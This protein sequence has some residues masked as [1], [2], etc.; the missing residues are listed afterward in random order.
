MSY[1]NII[2]T[3]GTGLVFLCILLSSPVASGMTALGDG[4][5]AA[6]R[7]GSGVSIGISGTALI[8]VGSY[9][10]Q[11]TDTKNRIEFNNIVWSNGSG[12]G[13]SF[14]TPVG[15]PVTHDIGTDISGRT[16]VYIHDSTQ[17]SPRTF[18][19]SLHFLEYSAG[20]SGP[21]NIDLGYYNPG[22]G[23]L[24]YITD[25]IVHDLG[26]IE[27][28]DITVTDNNLM[29]GAHGGLDFYQEAKTDI[30]SYSALSGTGTGFHYNYNTTTALEF[31]GIH[32]FGTPTVAMVPEDTSTWTSYPG[33]FKI[34]SIADG[35]AQVDIGTD[36]SGVTNMQLKLPMEG[37]IRVENV[38]FGGSDFGQLALDSINVHRLA[39]QINPN[40]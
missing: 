11:D 4:D 10:Y 40:P 13:F 7:G 38:K 30:G 19:A 20:Y 8:N 27:V 28:R 9:W 15:D 32:L 18:Y 37:S 5:L 31:N 1:N 29:I 2:K 14:A 36:A 35:P 21:N 6:C 34:G 33:T 17:V 22:N 26:S 3:F 25:Y 39:I 16:Y 12:G 23:D 24:N